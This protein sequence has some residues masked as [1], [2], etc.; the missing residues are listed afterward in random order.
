MSRYNANLENDIKLVWG[1]DNPLQE[2]FIEMLDAEGEHIFALGTTMILKAHPANPSKQTYNK[3][4][5]F[6]VYKK[7][8][9]HI[10][11]EHISAMALDLPF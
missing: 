4:E 2:Y 6:E 8:A 11:A 9:E 7:Y 1:Y 5:L 10:P 3:A